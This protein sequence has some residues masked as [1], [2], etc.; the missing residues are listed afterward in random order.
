MCASRPEANSRTAT[1]K[2]APRHSA[3][4]ALEDREYQLLLEGCHALEDYYS[5]EARL[6]VLAAGR[7]GMRVGEI[8]HMR[9]DWIDWRRRMIEIPQHEPCTKGRDGGICG[10]CRQLAEQR[11]DHN[12]DVSLEE[13]L[14]HRWNPK[15]DAA[16]RSIPFDFDPR[17]EIVLE[18]Y[19][20][21]YD[22][23]QGSHS[24]VHRRLDKAVNQVEEL[25]GKRV[26]PHALRARRRRST[27][28]GGWTR[29]VCSRFVVG[30]TYR[31]L[32]G[33]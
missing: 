33:T 6:I 14:R 9:E 1:S 27:P 2:S 15:T 21:K 26:Y 10:Y 30:A 11:V 3:D 20:E 18:R 16:V 22:E 25:D 29:L 4:D 5:I 24:A 12:D 17:C 7:L 23:F 19:F 13:A 28:L 32:T 8:I 31:R